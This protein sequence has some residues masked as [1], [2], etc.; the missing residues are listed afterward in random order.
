MSPNL[1]KKEHTDDEGGLTLL[2]DPEGEGNLPLSTDDHEPLL[3]L[4]GG[5]TAAAAPLLGLDPATLDGLAKLVSLFEFNGL[6]KNIY[7]GSNPFPAAGKWQRLGG[8]NASNIRRCNMH[9]FCVE[10]H[11]KISLLR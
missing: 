11:S 7:V 6:L 3:L 8:K 2:R 4:D 5:D 1:K 9:S 10:A